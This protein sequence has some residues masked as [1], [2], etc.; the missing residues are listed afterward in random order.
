MSQNQKQALE[1]L[2]L[3]DKYVNEKKYPYQDKFGKDYDEHIRG[4]L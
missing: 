3:M 2:S 1:L 4:R